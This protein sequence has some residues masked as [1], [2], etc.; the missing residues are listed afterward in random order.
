MPQ[1]HQFK[2]IPAKSIS[3]S[4]GLFE[5]SKSKWLTRFQQIGGSDRSML[6]ERGKREFFIAVLSCDHLSLQW[7]SLTFH[8]LYSFTCQQVR[9]YNHHT[10]Q[11]SVTQHSETIP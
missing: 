3:V 8:H 6:S 11:H 4:V 9:L 5:K 7:S 10:Q 1:G 2:S